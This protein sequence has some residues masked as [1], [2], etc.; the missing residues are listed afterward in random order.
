MGATVVVLAP[1]TAQAA[2]DTKPPTLSLQAFG[3]YE[4]GTQVST[5]YNT[6]D[7]NNVFLEDWTA[8]Y[9]IQ[10]TASD[11]SGICS[12]ALTEQNYDSQGGTN[13]FSV[14]ASQRSYTYTVNDADW[15]R[16]GDSFIVRATDC[17][18]NTATSK[19]AQT[20]FGLTED[21]SSTI[22]YTGAWATSNFAGFSG[23]T[24]HWTSR[25]KDAFT[26]A[27]N[28]GPIALMME[29]AANRGSASVYVDGTLRATVNTHSTTT[30]HGQ[31]VWQAILPAGHHTLRVVNKATSGHPRIDID[32]I[33][34]PDGVS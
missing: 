15:Q 13:T 7:P 6:S 33:L 20:S 2:G 26:F 14:P 18:G 22:T 8:T 1:V 10:W 3:H 19:I 28:G 9:Y 34:S 21:T 11:A 31:V 29:A 24:T 12:Q 4:P 17:A 16:A 5:Y 27:T 30:H 25:A 23:G 32:A